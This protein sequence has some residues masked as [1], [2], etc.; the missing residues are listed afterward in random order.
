MAA[1]QLRALTALAEDLSL[2]HSIR[3]W[4][5][6]MLRC[7]HCRSVGI[8]WWWN[9]SSSPALGF[10]LFFLLNYLMSF[11]SPCFFH[12][13]NYRVPLGPLLFSVGVFIVSVAINEVCMPVTGTVLSNVD[14]FL[15]P[16]LAFWQPA[17]ASQ[18][19]EKLDSFLHAS[20]L[21]LSKWHHHPPRNVSG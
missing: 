18:S 11:A 17:W 12:C 14:C 13:W 20:S 15:F 16:V 21:Y 8:R 7:W 6:R 4:K 9:R 5:L 3:C 1:P 19:K 10:H 2:V